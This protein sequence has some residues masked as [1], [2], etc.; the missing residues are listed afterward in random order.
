MK[1]EHDFIV[2]IPAYNEADRIAATIAGIR[3]FCS[4]EIVVISDG[5]TD[6]TAEKF[7]LSYFSS[8]KIERI[9]SL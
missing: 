9:C 1:I 8:W 2:L 5:S 6:S 7:S 3:E 4:A